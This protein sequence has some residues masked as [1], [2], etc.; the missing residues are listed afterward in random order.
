MLPLSIARQLIIEHLEQHCQKP[1]TET[2]LGGDFMIAFISEA[3][4]GWNCNYRATW[5]A[6]FFLDLTKVEEANNV[7]FYQVPTE[8][9]LDDKTKEIWIPVDPYKKPTPQSQRS[10]RKERREARRNQDR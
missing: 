6:S 7:E 9:Y 3:Q 10:D 1:Y 4:A 5:V 2:C 8:I